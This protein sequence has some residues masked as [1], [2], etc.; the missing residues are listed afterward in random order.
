MLYTL[1]V[2]KLLHGKYY[3]GSAANIDRRLQQ[4]R[5]G[6]GSIWTHKHPMVRCVCRYPVHHTVSEAEERS[7]WMILARQHG[8]HNVRGGDV[9]IGD[10]T[11]PDWCLPEEFGGSRLVDW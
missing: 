2:L 8:A 3:V 5:D 11:V 1:Y 10:E 6:Y 9:T 4:H 7:A